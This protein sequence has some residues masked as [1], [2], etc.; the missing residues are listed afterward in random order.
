MHGLSLNYVL[1]GEAPTSQARA[2]S[3]VPVTRALLGVSEHAFVGSAGETVGRDP[4]GS[5]T[6]LL[7]SAFARQ[8][9]DASSSTLG[10]VA[11]L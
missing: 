4:E 1:Y 10:T 11:L 5:H 7:Q 3:D 8:G 2:L 6:H 9:L